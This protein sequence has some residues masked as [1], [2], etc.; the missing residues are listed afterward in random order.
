MLLAEHNTIQQNAKCQRASQKGSRSDGFVKSP[1]SRRANPLEAQGSKRNGKG[2]KF[3][4]SFSFELS[5]C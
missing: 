2:D 1:G 5:A 3:G 4:F